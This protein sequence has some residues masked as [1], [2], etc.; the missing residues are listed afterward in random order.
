[1]IKINDRNYVSLDK[2]VY[3]RR[4]SAGFP[5]ITTNSQAH[6]NRFNHSEDGWININEEIFNLLTKETK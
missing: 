5:Q 2:I 4:D 3:V 1:M 6:L